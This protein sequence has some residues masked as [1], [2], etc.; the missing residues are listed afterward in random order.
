ME[1]IGSRGELRSIALVG[2]DGFD[3]FE[4]ENF[5]VNAFNQSSHCRPGI[6]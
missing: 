4:V 6:G 2:A 5:F 3:M 1:V